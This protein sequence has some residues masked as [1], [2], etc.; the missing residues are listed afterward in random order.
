MRPPLSP[1]PGRPGPAARLAA[2]LA[3]LLLLVAACG[4]GVGGTGTGETAFEAYGASPASVCSTDIAA[5]LRCP[6]GPSANLGT[7]AL[8][9]A[10]STPASKV[11]A[12]LLGDEIEIELRCSGQRFAG[13]F[14]VSR[15]GMRYYGELRGSA[16]G[17][18]SELAS[19]IAERNAEGLTFTVLRLDGSV[20]SGPLVLKAVPAPTTAAPC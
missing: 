10:E 9:Q 8:Y 15:L 4:A 6:S 1:T 12:T 17:A 2:P 13:R 5:N 11:L 19:V 16:A 14:G 7:A 3:A 18:G 20:A